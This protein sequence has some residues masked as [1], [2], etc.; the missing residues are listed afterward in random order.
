[1]KPFS[2][3][4]HVAHP[5]VAAG[6]HLRR[7][8]GLRVHR[9]DAA[10]RLRVVEDVDYRLAIGIRE[11]FITFWDRDGSQNL[12]HALI[13]K[14]TQPYKAITAHVWVLQVDQEFFTLPAEAKRQTTDA[15]LCQ[16]LKQGMLKL[17]FAHLPVLGVPGWWAANENADFYSDDTVFRK[18]RH[19]A[20]Q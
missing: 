18:P 10:A 11:L 5:R 19:A 13:E 16:G 15:L 3:S 1:M 2:V 4:G 6:W 9:W 14:L 20:R 7:G 8:R 17:P 12:G